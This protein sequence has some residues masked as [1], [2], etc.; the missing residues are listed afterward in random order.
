MYQQ[1]GYG[2]PPGRRPGGGGM[3]AGGIA[4]GAGAGLLGGAMLGSAMADDG[5]PYVENNYGDD[6]GPP[7]GLGGGISRRGKRVEVRMFCS[8]VYL[9]RLI[10]LWYLL[11]LGRLA[12][13]WKEAGFS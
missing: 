10:S 1:Q 6:G 13:C 2:M 3:G 7:R 4:M 12:G 11:R 8:T 9:T 5:D